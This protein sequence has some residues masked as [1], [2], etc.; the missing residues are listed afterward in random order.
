MEK[1]STKI[2]GSSWKVL[3]LTKSEMAAYVKDS[4]V[5]SN[6]TVLLGEASLPDQSVRV[7]CDVSD[8]V[9]KAT[10]IHE[11]VHAY[12][13]AGGYHVDDIEACC[14]FFGSNGEAIIKQANSL[15]SKYK[16]MTSKHK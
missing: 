1:I 4:D 16:S 9:M 14:D 6:D 12:A 2:L 3:F 10:A 5:W 11:L 13:F 8:E 7:R 15:V